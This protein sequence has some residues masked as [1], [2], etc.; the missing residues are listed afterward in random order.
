MWPLS[1]SNE[2]VVTQKLH[3]RSLALEFKSKEISAN[4]QFLTATG[5]PTFLFSFI[6]C[7]LRLN[8]AH[9][10]VSRIENGEWTALQVLEAYIARAALAHERTNCLTEGAS[11]T[12]RDL[13]LEIELAHQCSS[14]VL[15]S[16]QRNLTQSLPSPRN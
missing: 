2:A 6:R 5:G 16:V 4:N 11:H 9:E 13:C 7:H 10:I 12:T 8:T 14:L 3:E 15:G 1:S